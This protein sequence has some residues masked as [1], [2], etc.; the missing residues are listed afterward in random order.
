MHPKGFIDIVVLL[1]VF[2]VTSIS[3]T[4]RFLDGPERARDTTRKAHLNILATKLQLYSIDNGTYPDDGRVDGGECPT[5]G[6]DGA[7]VHRTQGIFG[8]LVDGNYATDLDFPR[9]PKPTNNILCGT[10]IGV[11]SYWYN[12][13]SDNKVAS[14]G[15]IL[16]ADV[17]RDEQA[18]SKASALFNLTSLENYIIAMETNIPTET[19]KGNE[20]VLSISSR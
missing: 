8:A 13:V 4:P 14:A 1:V 18:N 19:D 3:V 9:D 6:V 16:A 20:T 11:P 5:S 2:M 12:S 15:F 17:E 10:R 7:P